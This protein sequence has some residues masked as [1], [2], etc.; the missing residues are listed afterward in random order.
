MSHLAS[1]I[2]WKAPDSGTSGSLSYTY[3]AVLNDLPHAVLDGVHGDRKTHS[4]VDTGG[5]ENG[6][7]DAD[8][9]VAAI[10]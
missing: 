7:V 4:V 10:E 2:H 3:L 8:E 5:C 9:T 1:H 6:G